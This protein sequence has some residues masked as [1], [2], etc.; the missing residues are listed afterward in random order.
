VSLVKPSLKW[1]GVPINY[2][3]HVNPVVVTVGRFAN[4]L[5]PVAE[6][7]DNV[8]TQMFDDLTLYTCNLSI[9]HLLGTEIDWRED[10]MGSRFVFENPNANS[11]CGCGATFSTL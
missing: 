4:V 11:A 8:E 10:M 3:F 1:R 2:F 9:F 6:K 7:P 5:E